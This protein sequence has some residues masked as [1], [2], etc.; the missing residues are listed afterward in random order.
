MRILTRCLAVLLS[1]V[2]AAPELLAGST[3][4]ISGVVRDSRTRE[5]LP[6]VNVTVAG[7][8]LGASSSVDG[9]YVILNVPPGNVKVV[10]SFIGYRRF[11]VN[12]L[13]ISSDFTTQQDIDL[14]E[15]SVELDAVVIQAE[16]TPLIRQDLTNPVA[17]ISS[18]SIEALP[19]TDISEVIGLQAGVTV[20]DD[21]SI[22]IRGGLGNEIAYTLNGMNINNPYGNTRSVGVATNAVREVS[23]SSG[24]FS[25]EF[26]SA[27]SG[28]V[29]YVTRDGG[30]K[31][32][33]SVKQF[34]GDHVSS[35]KG[36]FYNINKIT[37]T[38][39]NRTEAT[40]GGPILGEDLTFF[41]SGVYNW[42]GGHLYG[43]RMYLPTDAFLSREGF[44]VG[45]PRRGSPNDPYY[46]AP[47]V[48]PTTDLTGRP[49]L[50]TSAFGHDS[51]YTPDAVSLNW[52]RSYNVQGNIAWRITPSIKLKYEFVHNFDE[53]PDADP[54]TVRFK[55]DGNAIAKSQGF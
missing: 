34:F 32:A 40:L 5:P 23:V 36:L 2:L 53:S 45:D 37:P 49:S 33:G 46:F 9:H 39:V 15:G 44:L 25:A 38:N 11:E 7:T 35:H 55:P 54:Y 13:R 51:T 16:R 27:L 50:Y 3:G 47:L 21:G 18:E 24:T 43:Q 41:A 42:N 6:G 48:N 17:S 52:S 10:A 22:H 1:V 19:V 14:V 20:D 8:S 31:W 26:G 30:V 29:N 28:V 4:K 12:D